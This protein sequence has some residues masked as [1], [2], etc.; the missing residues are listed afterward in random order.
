MLIEK[1][2]APVELALRT[3][4]T[5]ETPQLTALD[6]QFGCKFW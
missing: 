5:P 2:V 4:I 1:T 6:V 3:V